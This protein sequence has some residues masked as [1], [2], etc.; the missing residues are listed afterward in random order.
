M[1]TEDKLPR[2]EIVS[3]LIARDGDRCKHSECGKVFTKENPPTIDHFWLPLSKGGTWDLDNLKLMHKA[4]NSSKSDIIPNPDGTIPKRQ[5]KQRT[6][7]LPRPA[8]C[9]TCMNGRIL[10]ANEFCP[11]CSSGPQPV[12]SPR[13]TQKAPKDCS[14]SGIDHCWMCFIGHVPRKSAF[15]NLITG[16]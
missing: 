9:D 8:A 5:V 1:K 10:L 2:A 14:H 7:R 11:D 16:E 12:G 13:A 6:V 3:I 15:E 4:C